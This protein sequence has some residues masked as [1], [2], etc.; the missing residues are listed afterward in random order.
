VFG[1]RAWKFDAN[2]GQ[3]YL[4]LFAP[5]QPDLNWRNPQVKETLFG[6]CAFWLDR[7]VDGFRLDVA[8]MFV[9]AVDLPDNPR[10]F[11]LYGY[12]RQDHANHVNLPETHAIWKEF[13]QLLNR[14]DERMTVGEV[15]PAGAEGYYGHGDELHLVFNFDLI[16]QRWSA[17]AFSD[18]VQSWYDKLPD[19]AWPCWALNNHDNR[20]S[21]SRYATGAFTTARAKVAATMLL[22]LRGTP[23]LYYGEELGLPEGKIPR[24]EIVDPPGLRYWPFY[25]GRDGCRTPMPWD[26]TANAGFSSGKPWLRVNPDFARVNVESERHDPHSLLNYYQQLLTLRRASPALQ[27]GAYRAFSSAS[28]VYA[29]QRSTVDQQMLVALNFSSHPV[30]IN[31]DGEWQVRLSSVERVESKLSGTLTLAANEAMILEQ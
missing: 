13:R 24:A 14:Y 28:E 11:G 12:D 30:S 9:K 20:R 22:T 5:E 1:G 2:T 26:A 17:R 3:Y 23:F 29:Y 7:G 4:H 21:I 27:G 25:K 8:H 15:E 16:H 31:L 6:E 10:K 18:V 19:G